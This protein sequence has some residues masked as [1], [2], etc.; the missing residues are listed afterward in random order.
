[1]GPDHF[2]PNDCP[3]NT[4]PIEWKFEIN[5]TYHN[6]SYGQ[7]NYKYEIKVTASTQA[8]F[9]LESTI[10]TVTNSSGKFFYY[11]SLIF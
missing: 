8:G 7:P 3:K 5:D 4:L 10:S 1:M 9:G 2:V 11:F 6:F